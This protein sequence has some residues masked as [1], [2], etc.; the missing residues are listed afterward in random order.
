MAR[1]QE[2]TGAGPVALA[3]GGLLALASAIRVG[4]FVYTP[5][6]PAMV[7]GLRM[8]NSEAGLIASATMAIGVRLPA[9]EAGPGAAARTPEAGSWEEP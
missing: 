4:R 7:E 5:I 1:G 3:L 8:A 2:T 6:L 9:A